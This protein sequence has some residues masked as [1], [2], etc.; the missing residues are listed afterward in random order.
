MR[1]DFCTILFV[2]IEFVEIFLKILRMLK[3]DL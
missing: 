2:G 3:T 1:A